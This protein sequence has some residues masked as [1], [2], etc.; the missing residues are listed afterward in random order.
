MG[1]RVITVRDYTFTVEAKSGTQLKHLLDMYAKRTDE[2]LDM[3]QQE[4][5]SYEHERLDT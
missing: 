5:R 2:Q 1:Q 3:Y 4:Y